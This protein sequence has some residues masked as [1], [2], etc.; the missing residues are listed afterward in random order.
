MAMAGKPLGNGSGRGLRN[1]VRNCELF[2]AAL[3]GLQAWP[4]RSQTWA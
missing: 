1:P 4:Y 3:G 2:F